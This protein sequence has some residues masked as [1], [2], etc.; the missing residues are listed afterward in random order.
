M[1]CNVKQKFEAQSF[2]IANIGIVPGKVS[3]TDLKQSFSDLNFRFE[4][5]CEMFK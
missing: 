1:I 5:G 4:I 3:E 2:D